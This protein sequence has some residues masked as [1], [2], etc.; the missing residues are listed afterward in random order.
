MAID[1]HH[2]LIIDTLTSVLSSKSN[3]SSFSTR[4]PDYDGN[5]Y[6]IWGFSDSIITFT[7]ISEEAKS[8]GDAGGYEALEQYFQG[9]PTKKSTPNSFSIIIDLTQLPEDLKPRA[10]A[11]SEIGQK[12][13]LFRTIFLSG[14]LFK[15]LASV[16]QG[17]QFPPQQIAVRKNEKLWVVP[18]DSRVSFVFQIVYKD[19]NDASLAKIFLQEFQ[20]SKKQISNAP[21]ITF[22]NSPPDSISQFRPSTDGLFLSITI[23]KEQITNALEQAKYLSGL[24]QYLSYHIHSSKTYLHMRMRKRTD[25]LHNALK[26]AV[27]EKLE[28]KTFKKVRA[29]RGLKEEAKIINNFR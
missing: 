27:P 13:S 22:G 28:E 25:I 8:I 7:Y 29:T 17:A 1:P 24:K 4:I 12:F 2:P 18:G 5:L 19:F 10:L 23:L 3:V 26:Q 14:P 11:A 16:K 21:A 20:D 6:R 15:A 9:Y